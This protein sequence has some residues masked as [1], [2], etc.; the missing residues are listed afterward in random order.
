MKSPVRDCEI[1]PLEQDA[2]QLGRKPNVVS[3]ERTSTEGLLEGSRGFKK[4]VPHSL[5]SDLLMD[6]LHCPPVRISNGHGNTLLGVP[7]KV[8][9]EP[10]N[11][12]WKSHLTAGG[13]CYEMRARE[14]SASIH[15]LCLSTPS[16]A[17]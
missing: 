6:H 16:P 8:L 3:A 17:S 10:V 11:Q 12:G 4:Q 7:E 1:L 9:P 14:Q 2:E 15:P 5:L 13:T